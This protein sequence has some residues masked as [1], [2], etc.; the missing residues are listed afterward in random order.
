M[1]YEF[2]LCADHVKNLSR[3]AMDR[4]H[5]LLH[6]SKLYQSHVYAV[7]VRSFCDE[8]RDKITSEFFKYPDMHI[9][10]SHMYIRYTNMYIMLYGLLLTFLL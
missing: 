6:N 10:S 2:A 7:G 9:W 8:T 5:C 4:R 1:E 3:D